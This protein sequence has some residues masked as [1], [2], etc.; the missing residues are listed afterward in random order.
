MSKRSKQTQW[1]RASPYLAWTARPTTPTPPERTMRRMASSQSQ[2]RGTTLGS[3]VGHF[4]SSSTKHKLAVRCRGGV[5]LAVLQ[6]LA[7]RRKH[8]PTFPLGPSSCGE[9]L[10]RLRYVVEQFDQVHEKYL[11][12]PLSSFFCL[13]LPLVSSFDPHHLS[14]SSSS[15]HRLVDG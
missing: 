7:D 5:Q 15:S 3:C 8:E 1:F 4:W 10:P 2:V 14:A 11:S 9:V 12:V 13:A 6:G